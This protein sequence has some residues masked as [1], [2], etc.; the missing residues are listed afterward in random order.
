MGQA[1][2]PTPGN[3]NRNIKNDVALGLNFGELFSTLVFFC[4]LLVT[5]YPVQGERWHCLCLRSSGVFVDCCLQ[6]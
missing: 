6:T 2:D 5:E 1:R 4:M 3:Y